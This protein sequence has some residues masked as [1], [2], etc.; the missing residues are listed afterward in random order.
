MY[1]LPALRVWPK[2][3][4]HLS[5]ND[6][7]WIQCFHDLSLDSNSQGI[8]RSQLHYHLQIYIQTDPRKRL[9]LKT[10]TRIH[11]Q[12]THNHHH[13]HHHHD[14]DSH[15]KHVCSSYSASSILTTGFVSPLELGPKSA[16]VLTS[17]SPVAWWILGVD[18]FCC[19]IS[20]HDC[21]S[22]NS[23]FLFVLLEIW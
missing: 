19:S 11:C 20:Y 2:Y 9:R 12:T 15:N 18:Q 1:I 16:G 6:Q 3:M 8:S 4:P 21:P 13:H 10:P 23:S 17:I 14:H 5:R 7:E 22:S